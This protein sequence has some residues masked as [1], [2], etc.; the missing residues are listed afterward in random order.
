MSPTNTTN[1]VPDESL[2]NTPDQ[3]DIAPPQR[4]DDQ[5]GLPDPTEVGE[6]G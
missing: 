1:P 4:D 5:P 2:P 3:P 6:D